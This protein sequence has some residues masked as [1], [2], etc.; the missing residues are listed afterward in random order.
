MVSQSNTSLITLENLQTN[1]TYN[2]SA[3][4]ITSN[5]EFMFVKQETLSTLHNY[6]R[7]GNIS[8]LELT[9]Y[10]INPKNSTLVDAIIKW[11]PAY[12]MLV[13]FSL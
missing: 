4:I 8:E 3:T 11:K 2:V 12:G 5:Q 1:R 13:N 7:P 9:Q 10:R 6:Y